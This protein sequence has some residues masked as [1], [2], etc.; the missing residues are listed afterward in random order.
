MKTDQDVQKFRKE[1]TLSLIDKYKSLIDDVFEI[2]EEDASGESEED[3]KEETEHK[4]LERIKKRS[5]ALDQVDVFLNKIESLEHHL[6]ASE[7]SGDGDQSQEKQQEK[8]F[9]H[10]TKGRAKS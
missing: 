10:P 4:K 7:G 6:K 5:T 9:Q 8:G 1:K 2:F 3:G